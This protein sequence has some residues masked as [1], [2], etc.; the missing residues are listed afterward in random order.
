MLAKV[1]NESVSEK[2]M[3]SEL[4][5]AR[6]VEEHN[7]SFATADHFTKLCKVMFPDSKVAESFSCARTKTTALITHALA[8][9]AEEAVVSACQKQPF[10]ILCDGGNDN[11]HKKY[12]GILVR[13][14]DE[15]R[16]EV[17]VRF[18]DCPVC[19]I[20]TGQTLFQALEATLQSR[21]IPWENVIGFASDSA[22]VMVGIRN[23]VLSR[24]RERQPNVFSLGCV[25]HLAALC[26]TAALKNCQSPSM[27]SSSTSTIIS[28]IPRRGVRSLLSSCKIL[29]E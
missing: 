20:A 24:V 15:S 18:L 3:K 22:S 2:V 14:W 21:S 16:R 13:L 27:D 8:P 10:S 5:F 4:Y 19:N 1:S 17:V 25:C 29:M 23:S 28:N 6:F 26:A 11:F 12:F 7:L 9:S